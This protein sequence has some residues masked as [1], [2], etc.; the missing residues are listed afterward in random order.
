M[1]T[2]SQRLK[3]RHVYGFRC[4]DTLHNLGGAKGGEL[5]YFTAKVA[6]SHQLDS[7]QGMGKQKIYMRHGRE[8][9]CIA[10]H[11]IE[12]VSATGEEGYRP[13]VHIWSNV[14]SHELSWQQEGI[15]RITETPLTAGVACM[16]FSG[17]F[18]AVVGKD[19]KSTL[20]IYDWRKAH[21]MATCPAEEEPAQPVI[22][23]CCRAGLSRGDLAVTTVGSKHVKVWE[24]LDMTKL[25]GRMGRFLSLPGRWQTFTSACFTSVAGKGGVAETVVLTGAEDGSIYVWS[26]VGRLKSIIN[27]AHRG[28]VSCLSSFDGI[29]LV[30]SGGADGHVR[31]WEIAGGE[32][33]VGRI[34]SSALNQVSHQMLSDLATE[35]SREEVCVVSL[36]TLAK[37]GEDSAGKIG[38]GTSSGSIYIMDM[39]RSGRLGPPSAAV[40]GHSGKDGHEILGVCEGANGNLA[41]TV[42][43]DGLVSVWDVLNKC[44][45]Q[46]WRIDSVITCFDWSKP[47]GTLAN[48]MAFCLCNGRVQTHL[49]ESSSQ[50]KGV[51]FAIRGG[52]MGT[53]SRYSSE[54]G[55]LAV[56]RSDGEISPCV[57]FLAASFNTMKYRFVCPLRS[58]H[59]TTQEN[60]I[61][62]QPFFYHVS[63]AGKIDIFS[64]SGYTHVATLKG[65]H[66]TTVNEIDWEVGEKKLRTNSYSDP[67]E[68]LSSTPTFVKSVWSFCTWRMTHEDII[69]T[70]GA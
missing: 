44:Q 56:G 68:V 26:S 10:S 13:A 43:R 4:H 65:G 7:A 38:A 5:V 28:G 50:S 24:L 45:V 52:A 17:R 1:C 3:L 23:V 9:S 15:G 60:A 34:K 63:A 35:A 30:V 55:F 19:A 31:A 20:L 14:A 39:T 42:G 21:L 51:V 16:S 57:H 22:S 27:D 58:D 61:T 18:L 40:K 6:V 49:V 29:P 46:S 37:P 59:T 25:V 12:A 11:P 62:V 2:Q 70:H 53:C 66:Q 32:E 41:A 67:F 54:G 48:H 64:G 33:D 36:A 47:E 8:I 69:S